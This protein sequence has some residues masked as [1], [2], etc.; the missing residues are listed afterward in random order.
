MSD[1]EGQNAFKN[2]KRLQN[3]KNRFDAV[4]YSWSRYISVEVV[5]TFK[6]AHSFLIQ[7]GFLA[8][9]VNKYPRASTSGH[10]F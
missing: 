7:N 5:L 10:V 9:Y 1:H 4:I 6:D 2:W 3:L 8:Q